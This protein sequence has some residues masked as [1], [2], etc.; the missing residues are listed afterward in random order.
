[1]KSEV[2][3]LVAQSCLTLGNPM[4]CSPGS[5]FHGIFLDKNTGAGSH[6]LLQGIFPT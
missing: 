3:V 5:S 2:K 1:M 4:N 6:F